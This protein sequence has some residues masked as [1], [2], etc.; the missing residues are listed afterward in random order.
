MGFRTSE[1]AIADVQARRVLPIELS[2][3]ATLMRRILVKQIDVLSDQAIG[4]ECRDIL[5]DLVLGRL[6]HLQDRSIHVDDVQVGIGH[7]DVGL[8]HIQAL[9]DASG[10]GHEAGRL[11]NAF[12][13]R[14]SHTVES[15]QQFGR[16]ADD[17]RIDRSVVVTSRQALGGGLSRP[18]AAGQVAAGCRQQIQREQGRTSGSRRTDQNGQHQAGDQQQADDADLGRQGC[19]SKD[20]VCRFEQ[21]VH[22]HDLSL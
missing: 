8:D 7:H 10:L 15:R 11:P 4:I 18:H 20:S 2:Q 13:Q 21:N 17:R 16:F 19:S 1:N 12:L 5:P 14:A 3:Q 9:A 22:E 6:E